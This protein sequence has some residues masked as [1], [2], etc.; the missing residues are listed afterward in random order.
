MKMQASQKGVIW[1]IVIASI[2]LATLLVINIASTPSK[3]YV[4][5]TINA[6]IVGLNVPTAEE[7]ASLINVPEAPSVDTEKVDKICELTDGCEFYEINDSEG[8]KVYKKFNIVSNANKGDFKEELSKLL[9]INEDDFD[10]IDVY[11]K[12]K[13]VRAYTKSDK[14]DENYEVKAFVRVKYQDKDTD[15]YEVIYVVV[16]SV[17]DEGDYDELSLEEVDRHFEFE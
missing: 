3:A 14:D 12:D 6:A 10:V 4:Q 15:D 17:L 13:Q 16:T 1:A 5:D 9:D 11:T 8:S 2:I 7:I